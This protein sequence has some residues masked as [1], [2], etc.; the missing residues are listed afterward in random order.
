MCVGMVLNIDSI[1]PLKIKEHKRTAANWIS[2][3]SG[4]KKVRRVVKDPTG[5]SWVL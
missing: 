2:L 3:T 1:F 4:F 5:Y